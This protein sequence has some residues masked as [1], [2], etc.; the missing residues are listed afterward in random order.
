[1]LRRAYSWNL[2]T[3]RKLRWRGM[4]GGRGEWEWWSRVGEETSGGGP[5]DVEGE[6]INDSAAAKPC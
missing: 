6:L 5:K 1:M 3:G 2:G 4:G